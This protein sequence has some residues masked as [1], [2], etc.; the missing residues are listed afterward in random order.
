MLNRR[1]VLMCGVL[2]AVV[3]AGSWP[4]AVLGASSS[5]AGDTSLA[6]RVRFD[7]D[8]AIAHMK[9]LQERMYRLAELLREEEPE[10]SA[11]LMM[12]V[13]QARQQLI[14]EQMTEATELLA[15]LDLTNATAEQ[16]EIIRK[17]EELRKLLLSADLD[18][19]VKLQELRDLRAAQ[20]SLNRLIEKE[21][22]QREMTERAKGD[23]DADTEGLAKKE[24]ANRDTAEGLSKTMSGTPESAS[25][26]S[27]AAGSMGSASKK[28]GDAKPGEASKDQDDA[29]EQ[30]E[31][32]ESKLAEAEQKLL[33]DLQPL[34][35]DRV[36][37]NLGEMLAQEQRLREA[38]EALSP[39]VAEGRRQALLAVRGLSPNQ[40]AVAE[41]AQST[42]DLVEETRF[43]VALPPALG[44]VRD[45]MPPIGE[46]LSAGLA[47]DSVIY[48]ERQV[49]KDLEDLLTAMKDSRRSSKRN[50][51]SRCQSC[52]GDMNKLLAEVKLLR[53]MQVAVNRDT[54]KLNEER[55][56]GVG[57]TQ[58]IDERIGQLHGRQGQVRSAT[59]KLHGMT[60]QHCLDGGS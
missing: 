45:Q 3:F 60:C 55:T 32:A 27:G 12:G 34:V 2:L 18:L 46:D 56:Q 10:D 54:D 19:E 20:A 4:G 6:E 35:R 40:D 14:V 50:G 9:E 8:K 21:T 24:Q 29:L 41:L 51:Q 42:I 58:R 43:S 1:D 37:E 15:K 30:L 59:E 36:I 49:E 28:L 38:T 48:A 23:A 47:D 11:R 44:A 22:S 13:R 53:L 7:Q 5:T 33:E 39:G 52:G 31:E 17:L 25:L 26:V 57:S 16:L